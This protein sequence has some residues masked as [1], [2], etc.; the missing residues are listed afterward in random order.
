M[1]NISNLQIKIRGSKTKRLIGLDIVRTL[2]IIC[3]IGGHFFNISSN[4][5]FNSWS[6]TGVGMFLL[7]ML[8]TFTYIGVPLFLMLTGY[9]NIN[10]TEPTRKYYHGIWRVLITY[11]FFSVVAICYRE[12]FI[13]EHKSVLQW[14]H[15]IAYFG[16]NP[17]AWYIELWIG[18]FLLTP[19]LNKMWHAIESKR[20]RQILLATLFICS[21][22]PDFTN[23][24]G[25]QLMPGYWVDAAYPLLCFFLGC[26]FRT[27]KP[28][29]KPQK[30]LL[31]ILAL[32]LFNP[33]GSLILAPGQPMLHLQGDP[34]GIISMPIAVCTFLL[35]YQTD[36]QGR[37]VR[38][39]VTKIS[40][41]SLD[42]YLAAWMVD[43][44]VY[45]AFKAQ[46]GDGPDM[47][48][49]LYPVIVTTLVAGC[50]VVAYTKD[51]LFKGMTS[52]WKG[53]TQRKRELA[54]S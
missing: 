32:C 3:V 7:G 25:Y 23:R 1:L 52:A 48:V 2:A 18:L 41:L 51:V 45:P 34:Q 29:Y 39:L 42:M 9:L 36:L 17:Y 47:L 50:F 11:L 16:A 22:V 38:A 27:Y 53:L 54:E 12:V 26:Y 40:L 30:V 44:I 21:A 19:F 46:F 31:I 10:K 37:G 4:T 28:T 6:F 49:P 24:Y 5:D 15:A 33:V 20:H 13:G 35:L 14:C 43:Q 8:Q